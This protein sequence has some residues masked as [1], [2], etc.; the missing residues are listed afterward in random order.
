MYD[1]DI[2]RHLDREFMIL[3]DMLKSFLMNG[4]SNKKEKVRAWLTVCLAKTVKEQIKLTF[5][6]KDTM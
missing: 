5:P 6:T 2:K 1:I 4:K 3:Q